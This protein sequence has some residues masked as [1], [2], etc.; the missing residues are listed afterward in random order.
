M[1]GVT[2]ARIEA[3]APFRTRHIP[4]AFR[5]VVDADIPRVVAPGPARRTGASDCFIICIGVLRRCS[6]A[7]TTKGAEA[8]LSRSETLGLAGAP[9]GAAVGHRA[10]CVRNFAAI[11]SDCMPQRKLVPISAPLC[12]AAGSPRPAEVH[13]SQRLPPWQARSCHHAGPIDGNTLL[14][15]YLH[16]RGRLSWRA[17]HWSLPVWRSCFA[18]RTSQRTLAEVCRAEGMLHRK[19]VLVA[20]CLWLAVVVRLLHASGKFEPAPPCLPGSLGAPDLPCCLCRRRQ[21]GTPIRKAKI[22][23]ADLELHCCGRCEGFCAGSPP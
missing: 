23:E 18:R 5:G 3:G 17:M 9:Q 12:V 19:E 21:D 20:E 16:C 1:G 11:D 7:L 8:S 2:D 22:C 14:A 4:P 10:P 13:V 6:G 15:T